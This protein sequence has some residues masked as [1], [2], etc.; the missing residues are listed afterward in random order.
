M[1]EERSGAIQLKLV[2]LVVGDNLAPHAVRT[3]AATRVCKSAAAALLELDPEED[4]DE[5]RTP[6]SEPADAP[7]LVLDLT[8][9]RGV[10]R[11]TERLA[12]AHEAKLRESSREDGPD[13]R[14]E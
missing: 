1:I 5:D 6:F 14:Y 4:P 8:C 7:V 10:D 9:V 13:R 3:A 12:R 2:K 11:L